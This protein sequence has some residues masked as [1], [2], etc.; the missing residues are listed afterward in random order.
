[1]HLLR[2]SIHLLEDVILP[3]KDD[4]Q[5]QAVD[6]TTIRFQAGCALQLMCTSGGYF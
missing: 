4:C 6:A 5:R 1:M 3:D 2:M